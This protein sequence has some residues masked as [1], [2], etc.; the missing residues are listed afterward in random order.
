MSHDWVRWGLMSTARINE[1][2]RRINPIFAR[3]LLEV[4]RPELIFAPVRIR[5]RRK[6]KG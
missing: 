6:R 5:C 2:V 1:R 3:D 4:D